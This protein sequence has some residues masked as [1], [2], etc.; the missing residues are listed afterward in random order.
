MY[1]NNLDSAIIKSSFDDVKVVL[2]GT[3][4]G[5]K[6]SYRVVQDVNKL[7]KEVQKI[8]EVLANDYNQVQISEQRLNSLSEKKKQIQSI[9]T[10]MQK[11]G[12]TIKEFE[13][14]YTE[15]EQSK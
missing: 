11:H 4:K 5:L 12:L 14:K 15:K 9:I 13:N 8:D 3:Y 2:Q 10:V 1:F 7:R 6:H